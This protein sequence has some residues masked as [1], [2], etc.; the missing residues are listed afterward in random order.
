M[1][2]SLIDADAHDDNMMTMMTTTSTT[3]GTK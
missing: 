2:V 1:G 3:T